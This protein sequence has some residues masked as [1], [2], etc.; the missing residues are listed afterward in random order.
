MV[1][2][3]I[4]QNGNSTLVFKFVTFFIE[5]LKKSKKSIGKI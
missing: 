2:R 5:F 4:K 1:N 3:D